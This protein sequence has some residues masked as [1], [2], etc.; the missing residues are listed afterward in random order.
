M[1]TSGKIIILLVVVVVVIIALAA[2]EATLGSTGGSSKWLHAADYPL[3]VSGAF[4]VSGQQCL[5]STEYVYCI[6]G[7]DVDTAPRSEVYSSSNL[8]PSSSNLTSWTSDSNAYPKIINGQA[9]AAYSGYV[10]CVG[11]SDDGSGDDVASSYFAPLSGNGVVGNWAATTAYPIPIDSQYCA[12]YADHIF[13]VGG[14]NETDGTNLDSTASNSVWY[15]PI[16]SSGIGNWSLSTSYPANL[17]FPSCFAA[18]GYIYCLG[19]VDSNSNAQSTDYYASL[20]AEGVGTWTKT[21]SYPL[22]ETG[23]ACVFS[24]GYIYC[25]GGQGSSSYTNAVYYAT[26]SSA[27]IGSWKQAGNYPASV[28][29]T[30]VAVSGYI[31]CVGGFD[32]S[33]AGENPATYYALLTSLSDG[34]TSG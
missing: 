13:C 9:C 1:K 8:S 2:Y 33:A 16:S 14:N 31:Y 7:Q 23:Q 12:A 4:G 22:Q 27:G 3:Q 10:Y 5:N 6:G 26:A 15:A 20:S 30:C 11:G 32:G 24:S 28:G 18:S 19:G 17:Y 34:T 21:T 25:V 29:T